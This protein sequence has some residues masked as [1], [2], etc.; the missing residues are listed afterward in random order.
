[1]KYQKPNVL[2]TSTLSDTDVVNRAGENL[3]EIEDFMIDLDSGEII[4][5]VLSFGGFLGMGEKLFAVPFKS[6]T[7]DTE[8]E[9]FRLDV[10]KEQLENAPGFDKHDWPSH[11]DYSFIDQVY[12]YYGYEPYSTSRVTTEPVL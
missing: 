1:M 11:P 3:G 12:T 10:S 6:L 9:V 4:Y 5:A 2:S 8:N 7:V